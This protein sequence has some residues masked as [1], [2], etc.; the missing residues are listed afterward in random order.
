LVKKTLV[1]FAALAA[2]L[3][4]PSA[5]ALEWSDNSFHLAYGT[6]YREPFNP[7]NIGKTTLTY[8][9]VDGYKWGTN[10]LNIDF[11]YSTSGEGDNVQVGGAPFPPFNIPA[12]QLNTAGAME[13][14]AVYRHTLSF[15]KVGNT[16]AFSFGPVRDVGF[17]AGI[18]LNT[19]NHAFSSRKIMPIGGLGFAFNV[20]GFL[21][22]ELLV[23]KEWGVNGTFVKDTSFDVTPTFAANWGIPVYGPVTFE[24]W[25]AVNLPK[26]NGGVAV[27]GDTKTEV[28]LYPKVMVDVGQFFGSRGYQLGVGFEYWLNKF[29]VDHNNDP[30]GGSYAKT[31]FGEVAIHL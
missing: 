24:G 22:V 26:G 30:F 27:A 9:H 20:P 7:N 14:Y 29:G 13:V 8:T 19:K 2:V 18:D 31:V 21:N 12:Q 5:H 25:G 4:A 28:H 16:K 3:A 15:N 17:V 10:F 6:A 1:S 11:L 23:N